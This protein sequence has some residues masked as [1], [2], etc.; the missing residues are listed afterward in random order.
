MEISTALKTTALKQATVVAGWGALN[1]EIARVQVVDHP[2]VAIWVGPGTLLL[3][4]GYAW[5]KE[6]LKIRDIIFEF[7]KKGLAGAV[8]AVP[9]FLDG[10]PEESVTAAEEAGFPLLEIC[11]SVPFNAIIEEIN[12]VL[13]R[14][15]SALLE[16]AVQANRELTMAAV[17]AS[18][19]QDVADRLAS[20]GGRVVNVVDRDGELLASTDR[21]LPWDFRRERERRYLENA[22]RYVKGIGAAGNG[23]PYILDPISQ[24]DAPRRLACSIVVRERPEAFIFQDQA[25]VAFNEMDVRVIEHAA[26]LVAFQ[27]THQSAL[28][29]R[30]ERLGRAVVRSLLEGTFDTRA[31]AMERA[32]LVGWDSEAAYRICMV[33]LDEPM[34]LSTEG[35]HRMDRLVG[36][37]RYSLEENGQAPLIFAFGN[38]VTFL[39][40]EALKPEA[41][42]EQLRCRGGSMAVSRVHRGVDGMAHGGK[43]VQSLLEVMRPGRVHH[44]EELMFSLAL[45]GDTD[46]RMLFVRS[47]L[48]PLL[49]AK[50]GDM[51]LETLA[52]LCEEGFQ[53]ASTAR[54][55]AIHISTLRYRIYRIQTALG[56]NLEEQ[57]QRFELQVAVAL[58]ML[59]NIE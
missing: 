51:L 28:D 59:L 22:R 36:Q 47:R 49:E 23:Q 8:L 6:S 3:S 50:N 52:A 53:L 27:L 31:N 33:L 19:V 4:T 12:S 1:N 15:R 35:T 10:F 18:S 21:W 45:M 46:A 37:L 42:W 13:L 58:Q 43:D 38:Q 44:F 14:T 56:S 7:K 5:P 20:V 25:D 9:N 39:M 41:A 29:E 34:P 26:L 17:T 55:L 32:R 30:E 2:D 40:Q 57:N 11:W 54:R 48:D 16:R 24:S